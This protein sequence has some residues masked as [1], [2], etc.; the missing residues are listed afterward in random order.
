MNAEDGARTGNRDHDG[1][2]RAEI[3]A[4]VTDLAG[5][6]EPPYNTILQSSDLDIRA[7]MNDKFGV[8]VGKSMVQV[9]GTKVATW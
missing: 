3:T 5:R 6:M 2:T 8:D 4:V 9:I 1:A 7:R